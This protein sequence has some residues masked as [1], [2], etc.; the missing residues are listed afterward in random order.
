[1]PKN[2]DDNALGNFLKDRRRRIDPASLGFPTTR[3][4]T[5]GLR[6]EE[7]ALLTNVSAAWYTWLEQGRGGTPSTDVLDRLSRGLRLT[8][9]ER[10]H[11]YMLAQNRPPEVV[12][13]DPEVVSPGLQHL[14]DSL[15]TSPAAIRTSAW[16]VLAANLAARVVLGQGRWCLIG[17]TSWRT[18]SP[19]QTRGTRASTRPGRRRPV[20]WLPNSGPRPFRPAL[21]LVPRKWSKAW[22][23]TPPSSSDC[24]AGSM[25]GFTSSR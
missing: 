3:R 14:L 7:V 17:T 6:R 18:S 8:E 21:D 9:A 19:M 15:E 25:S 13:R 2:P 22:P 4:R 23:A 24:G 11:L 1:M 10:E 16:D 20:R 5:P 12:P